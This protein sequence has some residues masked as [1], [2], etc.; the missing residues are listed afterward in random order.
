MWA[1]GCLTFEL[2][3][4]QR[5]F[6]SDIAIYEYARDWESAGRRPTMSQWPILSQNNEELTNLMYDLLDVD[7]LKRPEARN[8]VE[9]LT[10]ILTDQEC[11]SNSTSGPEDKENSI[12]QT[13]QIEPAKTE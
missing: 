10:H 2:L 7:P 9:S 5:A 11:P 6:S 3:C 8:V 1:L 13:N 4:L 12:P